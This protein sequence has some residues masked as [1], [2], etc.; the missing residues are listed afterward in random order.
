MRKS[1][2]F[3]VV[4][5]CRASDR[6]RVDPIAR[7][8]ED[9][10]GLKVWFEHWHLSAGE[11]RVTR[12]VEALERTR[13]CVLFAGAQGL[14]GDLLEAL[15]PFLEPLVER[16]P[17]RLVPVLLPGGSAVRRPGV[18]SWLSR[19]SWVEW[20]REWSVGEP[21]DLGLEDLGLA[22]GTV[23]K[24]E[25]RVNSC[26]FRGL[27]VFREQDAPFFFGRE[28]QIQRALQYLRDHHF[29]T[30]QGP[31]GSGKSSFVQAGLIPELRARGALVALCSPRQHPLEELALVL[32][33]E[34]GKT[35]R[36]QH[37]DTLLERLTRNHCGLHFVARELVAE[38]ARKPFFL[39]VDQFE[40][41]FTQTRDNTQRGIFLENLTQAVELGSIKLIVAMRSDF[42]DRCARLPKLSTWFREH[43]IQIESP[44][45]D[46]LRAAMERPAAMAGLRFEAGLVERIIAEVEAAA[47]QMPLLGFSLLELYHRREGTRLTAAAYQEIG[48]IHG[49]LA[50]RAQR[51]LER[52]TPSQRKLL[53]KMFVFYLV[54]P[55]EGASNT[56]RRVLKEELLGLDGSSGEAEALVEAWTRARLLTITRDESRG[57][58]W[59]EVAHDAMVQAWGQIRTWMEKHR[60]S[61]DL[62][63][64]LRVATREWRRAGHHPDYLLQGAPLK[65]LED[66][67]RVVEED[68]TGE[69]RVFVRASI[70]KK[71]MRNWRRYLLTTAMAVFAATILV[72]GF[73][74][75]VERVRAVKESQAPYQRAPFLPGD[76]SKDNSRFKT[77]K[78]LTSSNL[79]GGSPRALIPCFR[80]M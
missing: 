66:W 20:P 33:M 26:P 47:G 10:A 74:S 35:E 34:Q 78:A 21:I 58:D 67:F 46:D 31:S 79:S 5:V 64:R 80:E 53:R 4:L 76:L 1:L 3:D 38:K 62:L 8:L 25:T 59:V 69:E 70:Q 22:R 63:G 57:L 13:S 32:R 54:Q 77:A 61:V 7:W 6:D 17:F 9:R 44:T 16:K 14:D 45:G 41:L 48:G 36:C 11:Q 56:R 24:P 2:E 75:S 68:L 55:G 72:S 28:A 40:E 51:E 15:A 73:Q 29:L 39:I 49:A 23:E 19:L 27:Q 18:P 50:Q 30:V 65:H 12:I 43:L 60:E 37:M 52:L 42:S 71:E